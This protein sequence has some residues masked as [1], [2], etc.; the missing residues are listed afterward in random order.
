MYLLRI[1]AR[2][3]HN[4]SWSPLSCAA[5]HK[6]TKRVAFGTKTGGDKQLRIKF[7]IS[8]VRDV[9]LYIYTHIQIYYVYI[10]VCVSYMCVCASKAGNVTPQKVHFKGFQC[11]SWWPPWCAPGPHCARILTVADVDPESLG[12][13][14]AISPGPPCRPGPPRDVK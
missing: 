9:D 6:D 11:P 3:I 5:S 2:K 12:A 8:K 4:D 1:C 14:F 13:A 10:C 7:Y